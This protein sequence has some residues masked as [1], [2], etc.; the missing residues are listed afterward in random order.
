MTVE[1]ALLLKLQSEDV[2][3]ELDLIANSVAGGGLGYTASAGGNVLNNQA[4]RYIKD[5]IMRNQG[6][7]PVRRAGFRPAGVAR[8]L[9]A[10]ML[11]GSGGA[12]LAATTP[13]QTAQA[14]AALKTGNVT[15][16]QAKH[17]EEVY[18]EMVSTYG[19]LA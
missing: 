8:N 13:S 12:V 10:S 7:S 18:T 15:P 9:V 11:G 14:L 1:E 4:D 3:S 6:F 17:I 19:G 16:E 5:P 2:N